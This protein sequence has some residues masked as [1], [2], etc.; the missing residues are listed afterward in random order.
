MLTDPTVWGD[1]SS[2][3]ATAQLTATGVGIQNV[4]IATDF[5]HHSDA[6]IRYGLAFANLYG[7]QT[8]IVY[9]M[10]TED[11][12]LAGPEG[13]PAAKD[14]ARRDLL[15]FKSRLRR[16]GNIAEHTD[17][18]VSMLE[19]PVAE[20]LLQW[21]REKKIDLIVVGTHGR[22]GLGKVILG[23]VAEKIFRHSP[24]P[25]LTVGPNIHHP[26]GVNQARQILAP[27]DLTSRSHPAVEYASV[28]A[29]THNSQL[30]VLHV[31]EHPNEGLKLDPERVKEGIRERL[32][33]IVGPYSGG[34]DIR[35]RVEFGNVPATILKVA[36]EADADFIVLGVRP[37]SGVFDRFMWPIAY[38]L[39]REAACP[40]LT[41]R[42]NLPSR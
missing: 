41:I 25:V 38:E 9:V 6:A 11:Y 14:A 1:W 18:H 34:V 30:T 7:A 16:T 13:L 24:V 37:S 40:V 12:V 31:I 42:R 5:S 8:E 10:P 15:E 39:V 32:A 26:R 22:G 28:L 2:I 20:C 19:G 36:S 35:Y 29:E 17:L 4:L 27:C 33:E 21:A 23:S 3:M